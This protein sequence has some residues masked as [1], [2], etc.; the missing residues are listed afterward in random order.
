MADISR[1]VPNTLAAMKWHEP[2]FTEMIAPLGTA[3]GTRKKAWQNWRTVL[4]WATGRHALGK[5]LPMK[6]DT[7]H[8]VLWDFTAMG[9]LTIKAI[10]D[11]VIAKHREA[12][13]ASPVV[14]RMSYSRL[15]SCLGRLLG[16]QQ[17]YKFGFTREMVVALLRYKPKNLVEFR[18][19]NVTCT[20]TLGCMRP[21]EEAQATTCCLRY[22]SDFLKGLPQFEHLSTLTTVKRKQIKKGKD[23]G[24]VLA[25]R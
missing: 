2:A 16:K 12:R 13:L 7:L 3:H 20:L 15:S 4:T 22:S 23:F 17:N 25:M 5:I 8:A 1:K 10:V 24:F 6:P 21:C 11:V 19:K 18:N 9:G 14:G